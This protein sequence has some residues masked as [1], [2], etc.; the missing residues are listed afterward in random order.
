[1]I[2]CLCP[3]PSIDMFAW[4]ESIL[5]G[6]VNR[7]QKEKRFPGGKGVHVALAAAELGEKVQLLAF[8]GGPTGQWVKNSCEELG[9]SCHGP[10]IDDWSRTCMTFKSQDAYRD[11]ELL[12]A[13]PNIDGEDFESFVNEYRKLVATTDCVCMSGSWPHGAPSDAYAQLI[14]IA[15][16]AEAP[17]LLDT[18]GEQL[19]HALKS[20]PVAVHL[21]RTEIQALLKE[22]DVRTAALFLA[23]KCEY[24]V[25][26]SGPDGLYLAHGQEVVHAHCNIDQVYSAVGSGDCLVAGFAVAL[27]RHMSIQDSARLAVACGAANCIR[28]DLG[29][30]YRKDVERLLP[31]VTVSDL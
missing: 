7:I 28:E 8:W 12:G 14:T 20:R 22:K 26:T 29:M 31:S 21:N 25:V 2:L 18:T 10:V 16:S 24:A 1:M 15:K 27:K 17:V 23:Q 11:T 5:P 3:N 4:V 19:Q 30:L 13:G 6:G 9:V